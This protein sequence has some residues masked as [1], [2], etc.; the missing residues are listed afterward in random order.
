MVSR[1][2]LFFGEGF[3]VFFLAAGVYAVFS[4][5]VWTLWLGLPTAGGIVPSGVPPYQW[6]AHEM[7]FG[8]SGA[9][10][11]GFLLTAVPNWTGA[12]EARHLFILVASGIW[13]GGRIAMWY[14]GVLPAGLVAVVDLGFLPILGAKI[15]T[16]LVRRPKPQNMMFLAFLTMIWTGNLMVHLEWMGLS[17]DTL[18]TGMRA[19]LIGLMSMI[20]VL[21]GR[22]TPAFTR[23]AMKR[24]ELPEARWPVSWAPLDMTGLGL[25]LILPLTILIGLPD[26]M[27]GALAVVSGA[28]QLARL[29][30]WRGRWTL[31]QPILLAL[32]LGMGMLGV[33][34]LA[35]GLALLGIGSEIAA[36]HVLGIG[37]A[38][39]MTLA[40]M[41]RAVLGHSGRPLVA[42]FPVAVG[43]LMVA[44]A[45]VLRWLGAEL[46]GDWYMPL[47]LASGGLWVLAFTLYT[48]A[49]W[50]AVTTP[51]LARNA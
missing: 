23:N 4:V 2:K 14:S 43:Y 12:K 1:L 6:H 39:G 5:L 26:T 36:L 13:L 37:A 50:P 21:G 11:G 49:I 48:I 44:A 45:A 19:G 25:A 24:D 42:P 28:V 34:L 18:D 41:S 16:Q 8:F 38:G 27:V 46:P 7:I 30:R 20:A 22:V 10:L 32:H 9:A 31:T 33:G 40:V 17:A 47:I 35:W 51:K 15:A 29:A 3:R